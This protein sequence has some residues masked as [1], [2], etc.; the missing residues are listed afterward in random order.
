M[1]MQPFDGAEFESSTSSSLNDAIAT[2]TEI[3]ERRRHERIELR[4]PGRYMIENIGEFPCETIDVSPGGLR[5]K[6][7]KLGP[8]G[9]RV[10]AYIDGLGRVE[11]NIVRK[12]R[13]WFAI[14]IRA[15]PFK[16]DRLANKINWLAQRSNE[17]EFD[18]RGAPRL[19]EDDQNVVLRTQDGREYMGELLDISVDGAAFLV[20]A[21]LGVDQTV[22]LGAQV[23]KV[24]HLFAGGAAVKFV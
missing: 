24:V 10:V 20:D 7:P 5:L 8:W 21:P 12:S 1:K 19:D 16:E 4:L 2:A 14:S 15:L 13:G 11:G 6:G 9:S 18:R 22:R 17:D 3:L 23:A